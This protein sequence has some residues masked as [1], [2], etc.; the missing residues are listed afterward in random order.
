MEQPN[1]MPFADVLQTI[2]DNDPMP[3]HLLFRL[4]DLSVSEWAQFEQVWSGLEPDKRRIMVRH[5]ADLSEDN[6]TVDFAPVFALGLGDETESVR[7]A[8]LD[9]LWDSSDTKLIPVLIE[10]MKNDAAVTVRAAAAGALAHFV[11][12]SEW[13]EIGRRHSPPIIEAMLDVYDSAETPYAVRRATVEALGASSHDRIPDIIRES[14][15][16]DNRD[17]QLSAVFA[18]GSSADPRWLHIVLGEMESVDVRMREVAAHAAGIIGSSDA[19]SGLADLLEDDAYEVQIAAVHALGQIGGE[20][21]Q[22]LLEELM[23][24]EEN[25]HLQEAVEEALEEMDWSIGELN[26]FNV[27]SDE[28]DSEFDEH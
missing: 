24:D 16:S 10:V 26:L 25:E 21:A 1:E 8:A 27:D 13:G 5:L 19:V 7:L 4:S 18:M 28:I 14:Y 22:Q 2:V 12:M 6:F 15:E 9:G 3:V 20:V 23:D 11:M 17:M